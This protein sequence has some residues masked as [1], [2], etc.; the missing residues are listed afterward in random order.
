[1]GASG[2]D[3]FVPYKPDIVKALQDLT[4]EVFQQGNYQ[5]PHL[6]AEYFR[7]WLADFDNE[8]GFIEFFGSEDAQI[9][10][11]FAALPETAIPEPKTIRELMVAS[12]ENGTHSVIDISEISPTP[13]PGAIAPLSTQQLMELFG[14][15]AP[16][17]N[18]I[19]SAASEIHELIQ[20]RWEGIYIVVYKD[21]SPNEIYFAGCSGD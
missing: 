17:R 19:E 4:E 21:G 6:S 16:E 5:K 9:L 13:E 20:A 12:G 15:Q 18:L 8:E 3:Y 10:K 1:M 2:W 7:G 14:T 11:R